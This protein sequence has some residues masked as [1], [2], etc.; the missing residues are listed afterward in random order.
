MSADTV[1]DE[2]LKKPKLDHPV[3]SEAITPTTQSP[4]CMNELDMDVVD[5]LFDDN[6]EESKVC[7]LCLY[8]PVSFTV[9]LSSTST[10]DFDI[11][12]TMPH[13][14]NHLL[15]PHSSSFFNM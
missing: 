8:V 9:N 5:Y 4:D 12:T 3:L 14:L 13:H 10:P 2:P 15:T 6:G 7:V 1:A 11:R